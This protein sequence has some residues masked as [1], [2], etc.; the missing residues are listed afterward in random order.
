MKFVHI[1]GSCCYHDCMVTLAG[2]FGL[3]YT[4]SFS[5]LWSE[6][7]LRYDSICKVFLTRRMPMALEDMGMKLALPC[8]TREERECVWTQILPGG[9]VLIGMDGFLIPWNPIYK[10]QHGPHYFITE[11]TASDTQTC[12]D[13]TYG[14]SGMTLTTHELTANS[15]ALIPVKKVGPRPHCEQKRSHDSHLVQAKEVLE[16]HPT[17]LKK[18]LAQA[19]VWIH[20]TEETILLPARFVDALLENRFLYL[21]YLKRQFIPQKEAALFHDKHYYESWTAV[22]HGF[23]KAALAKNS[24]AFQEACERLTALFNQEIALAEKW[25]SENTSDNLSFRK[26][27]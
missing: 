8:V 9:L 14:L 25:Y 12:Y 19:D 13:P 18:L 26:D 11:K 7:D 27:Y 2:A 10:L 5:G 21:H 17:T 16:H 22:K 23:F 1:Q 24:A 20:G 4:Q 6:S 15:F 3:D